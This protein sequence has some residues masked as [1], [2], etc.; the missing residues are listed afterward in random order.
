MNPL[1]KYIA[2]VIAM[3]VPFALVANA[4]AADE[5]VTATTDLS[6]KSGTFY[7]EAQVASELKLRAEV[8]TPNTSP[9]VNPMK[10]VKV[11]FPAG[12]TF[13]PNNSKTPVCPDSKLS[14]SSN[15]SDPSGVVSACSKSVVGTGTAAIYLAKI[16]QPTALIGDPILVVFNAGTNNSNQPK[17]K[18]YSYS[19]TTNVGILMTG[20]LKG[21]VLD[22]AVPVLSNDSAVK[23]FELDLPG[24]Q[25]DRPDIGVNTH[26]LD[27]N[28]VQAKCASSPLKT[29][30]VFELGERAYPSGTETGPTTTVTSPQ[31]TQ[32]C[33]GN[34]GKVKLGGMKVKGPSAVKN[35]K[36]GTYKVTVKNT[37]TRTAKN[38]VVTNNRG[39][40]AK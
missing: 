18:I 23:Y 35:G 22:I 9:K 33:V 8:T 37:G 10:N 39:G 4:N 38:V 27:P 20:T 13:K 7:K 28:Y 1:K 25:L 21:S 19:K 36:K 29:N 31:T 5:T 26:G 6:P 34:A 15:L 11:T 30:A 17:L 14:P 12:M 24:D 3:V 16:N 40:K 32:D 2:L